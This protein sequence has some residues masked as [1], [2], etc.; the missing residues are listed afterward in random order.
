MCTETRQMILG[1]DTSAGQCAVALLGADGAVR[2]RAAE[3]MDRGHAEALWPMIARMM[4][5]AGATF[6]DLT[7]I[8]V[9]TGP[10]SFTG[11]RVGVAAARGLGLGLGVP[12]VGVDRLRAIADRKGR[13]L[14]ALAGPRGTAYIRAFPAGADPVKQVPRSALDGLA[15]GLRLGDGWEG[16]APEDGLP[17]SIA[18]ARLARDGSDP[19]KPLYVRGPNADPPHE[20]PPVLLD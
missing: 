12:V 2:A 11:I 19:A 5:E 18:I 7:R 14:V 10:G 8:G 20:K 3:R 1:V 13:C 15:Q 17:D 16:A 6:A 9:C 4:A